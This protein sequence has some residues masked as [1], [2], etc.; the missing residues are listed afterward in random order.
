MLADCAA[1]IYKARLMLMHIAY[2]AE[3]GLDMTQET[4]LPKYFWPIWFIRSWIPRSSFMGHSGTHEIPLAD[5]YTSIR[6]QRLVDGPDEVHRWKVGKNVLR[7][8]ERDG[9]TAMAAG[10]DLL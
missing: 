8:Y 10:G 6:S 1:E 9:T 7:A 4:R 3:N 2:K 5:W